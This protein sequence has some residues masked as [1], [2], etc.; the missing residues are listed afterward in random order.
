MTL[1]IH[2][3]YAIQ[4]WWNPILI[5]LINT[6][7]TGNSEINRRHISFIFQYTIIYAVKIIFLVYVMSSESFRCS[8]QHRVWTVHSWYFYVICPHQGCCIGYPKTEH[9]FVTIPAVSSCIHMVPMGQWSLRHEGN[10][11]WKRFPY[12]WPFMRR[13]IG[14]S[15]NPAHSQYCGV[16]PTNWS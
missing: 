11:V 15:V 14:P 6:C 2:A 1:F 16:W 5:L 10:V 8:M 13:I 9:S 7:A 3:H 12:Y 4:V